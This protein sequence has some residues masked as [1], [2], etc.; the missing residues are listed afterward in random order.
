MEGENKSVKLIQTGAEIVGAIVGGAIGLIGGP[1]FTI[2]GS[3]VG[4]TVSK[5]I[6]EFAERLLSNREKRE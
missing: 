6:G 3:V 4:V 1:V 5:T 2:G